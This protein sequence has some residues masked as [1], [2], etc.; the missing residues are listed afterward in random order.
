[1]W[2][3]ENLLQ[4]ICRSSTVAVNQM[5][6]H[7]ENA[8]KNAYVVAPMGSDPRSSMFQ[9]LDRKTVMACPSVWVAIP[10]PDADDLADAVGVP[11]QYR[12]TDFLR[13]N[14]K[15]EQKT[16]LGPTTPAWTVLSSET[17]MAAATAFAADGYVKREE[18]S[19]G[20]T[21]FPV[22]DVSKGE[23]TGDDLLHDLAEGRRWYVEE[24]VTGLASSIQCA[25]DVQGIC[26]FGVS[27]QRI[28]EGRYYAGARLRR[29]DTLTEA[30]RRQL[31]DAIE[32]LAPLLEA[33][34]GFFGIDYVLTEEGRVMVL[35]ANIR[36][37]AATVPTLVFNDRFG[38]IG[39]YR[40]D[41]PLA[42]VPEE[43]V[44]LARNEAEGMADILVIEV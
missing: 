40:E 14:N 11:V 4:W 17:P 36:L 2:G 18:G 8:D 23:K 42:D 19:G 16:L 37:T 28:E 35:E 20:F 10:H 21:V 25:K 30:V 3:Y 9:R 32:R 43:A 29:V 24:R 12:Y 31:T 22:Q 1:M 7:S 44:V 15:I 33:Y 27:E 5:P 34:T 6:L 13:R 26:V 41:V 38:E 39:M